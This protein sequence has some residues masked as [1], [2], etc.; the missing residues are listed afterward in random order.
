MLTMNL[1]ETVK[2]INENGLYYLVFPGLKSFP[3]RHAV[4]TRLGG[5]SEG[6]YHSLNVS[7]DVGDMASCVGKKPSKDK[8]ISRGRSFGLDKTSPWKRSSGN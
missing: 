8:G 3:L 1:P 5:C 2:L 4:F 6:P 7:H